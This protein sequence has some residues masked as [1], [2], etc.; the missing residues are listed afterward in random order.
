VKLNRFGSGNL[1]PRALAEVRAGKQL[2]DIL[3]TNS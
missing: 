3:Q 1:V 2:S